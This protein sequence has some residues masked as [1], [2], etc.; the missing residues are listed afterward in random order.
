MGAKAFRAL[1][2]KAFHGGLLE[3]FHVK[4]NGMMVSHLQFADD[5]LILCKASEEQVMYLRCVIRCFKVVS[6]LKV[7]FHKS[8]MYGIGRVDLIGRLANCLGCTVGSL[9]TTYL[10]LSLGTSTKSATPWD[11]VI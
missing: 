3:G 4:N 5:T 7:N 11:P 2:F 9:P 6:G 10:G 1:L 8:G